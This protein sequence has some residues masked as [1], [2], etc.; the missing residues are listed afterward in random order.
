[1]RRP[2]RPCA[3]PGCPELV[4]PPKVYCPDHEWTDEQR[5]EYRRRVDR[6]YDRSRRDRR[7][8]EFYKSK[9]WERVRRIVLTR[10]EYLCQRCLEAR[11]VR[12][13]TTVD[14]I[15]PISEDWGRRLDLDNLRALCDACHNAVRSEQRRASGTGGV[16][17]TGTKW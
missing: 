1:M 4:Q 8:R 5:R 7:A 6:D 12:L 2:K 15:V 16:P 3:T 10:D 14:H 11:R 13:A 17:V 9:E